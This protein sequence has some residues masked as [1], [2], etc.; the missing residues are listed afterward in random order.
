MTDYAFWVLDVTGRSRVEGPK[1]DPR[2]P[3]VG[4][5][6][7]TRPDG[8]LL[9]PVRRYQKVNADQRS[10]PSEDDWR[11]LLAMSKIVW[12]EIS[13]ICL[14]DEDVLV[15][16]GHVALISDPRCSLPPPR[17]WQPPRL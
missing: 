2:T 3:G 13:N 15:A 8:H 17:D 11:R 10:A 7:A 1:S 16:D 12:N 14:A 5:L 9:G 6:W 4:L